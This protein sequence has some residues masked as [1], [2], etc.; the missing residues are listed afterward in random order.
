MN[1]TTQNQKSELKNYLYFAGTIYDSFEA[2]E[3]VLGKLKLER[4]LFLLYAAKKAYA[5]EVFAAAGEKTE[6]SED[7]MLLPQSQIKLDTCR[8]PQQLQ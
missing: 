3:E 7:I 8:Y 5:E 4:P 6:K 1:T 2:L